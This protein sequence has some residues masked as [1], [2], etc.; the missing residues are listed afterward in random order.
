MTEERMPGGRRRRWIAA[1]TLLAAAFGLVSAQAIRGRDHRTSRA[2]AGSTPRRSAPIFMPP[3]DGRFD[4][5]ARDAALK[6]L[7]GTGL[8]DNVTD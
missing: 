3:P 2:I 4:E 5:A 7:V 1:G 6:A 8:F